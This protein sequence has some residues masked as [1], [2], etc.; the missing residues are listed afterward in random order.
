MPTEFQKRHASHGCYD[1][2]IALAKA[3]RDQGQAD[4]VEQALPAVIAREGALVQRLLDGP[5]D[6]AWYHWPTIK[7]LTGWRDPMDAQTAHLNTVRKGCPEYWAAERAGKLMTPASAF[8]AKAAGDGAT[9]VTGPNV[10]AQVKAMAEAQLARQRLPATAEAVDDMVL[11]LFRENPA[12]YDA[13][14]REQLKSR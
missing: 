4:T 5:K 2:L 6:P 3:H 14:V 1:T 7:R 9:T 11:V 13:Y 10:L 8:V 12:L